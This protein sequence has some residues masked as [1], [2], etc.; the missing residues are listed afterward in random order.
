[1]KHTEEVD[2]KHTIPLLDRGVPDVACVSADTGDVDHGAEPREPFADR[3]DRGVDLHRVGDVGP[4]RHDAR[5]LGLVEPV[6]HLVERSTV[7]VEHRNAGTCREAANGNGAT[8]AGC[9][10]GYEYW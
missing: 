5:P 6:H 10:A 3:G 2:R 8:D 7:P 1:V 9:R 4:D